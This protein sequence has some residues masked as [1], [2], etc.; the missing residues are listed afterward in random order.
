MNENVQVSQQPSAQSRRARRLEYAFLGVY[1][2]V[3]TPAK[4]CGGADVV[5]APDTNNLLGNIVHAANIVSPRRDIYRIALNAEEQTLEDLS[6][7]LLGDVHAE[8]A[9][10]ALALELNRRGGLLLAAN[11]DK[12][13]DDLARTEQ[14]NELTCTV[15][16]GK[17]HLG[18][19]PLLESSRALGTHSERA[20][21]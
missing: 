11:V 12:S 3:F 6:H 8:E 2:P 19:E 7:P 9:V 15:E 18:I 21:R 16:R 5:I 13:V 4:E 10:D 1:S 14:L 20:G 17:R